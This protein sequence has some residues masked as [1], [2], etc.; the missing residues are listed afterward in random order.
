M[1]VVSEPKNLEK[2]LKLKNKSY[3]RLIILVLKV[4][5]SLFYV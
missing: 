1:Y 4:Y 2:S 3:S 5:N